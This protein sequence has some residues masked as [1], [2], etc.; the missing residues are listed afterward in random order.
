MIKRKTTKSPLEQPVAKKNAI[1]PSD[2]STCV[3]GKPWKFGLIDCDM[4]ITAVSNCVQRN[5]QCVNYINQDN[6][7]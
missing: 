3:H 6:H 1:I 2:C 5:I 7:V 4:A